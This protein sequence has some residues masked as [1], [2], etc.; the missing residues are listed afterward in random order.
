M[1]AHQDS[2]AQGLRSHLC[3]G[4]RE[5]WPH[6]LRRLPGER[7]APG[8]RERAGIAA[9][10][11]A[12]G[13]ALKD[14]RKNWLH[15]ERLNRYLREELEQLPEVVINSPEG[16]VPYVLNLSVLPFTTERLVHEMRMRGFTCLEA[17]PAKRGPGAT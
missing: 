11:L 7:P 8:H 6:L 17:R 12:A 4:G 3:E 14:I 13:N 15:V 2:R 9:F 16:A 10:G 1:T 5:A